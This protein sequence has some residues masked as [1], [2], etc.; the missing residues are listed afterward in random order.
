MAEALLSLIM[1]VVA[2]A[3]TTITAVSGLS[4]S[5]SVVVA[6]ET[7]GKISKKPYPNGIKSIPFF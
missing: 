5:Y 6:T 4:F 2:V 3:A 7:C 1:V